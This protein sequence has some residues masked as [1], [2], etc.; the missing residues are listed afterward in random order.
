MDRYWEANLWQPTIVNDGGSVQRF[1]SLRLTEI[2][3]YRE[4]LRQCT[5]A[6]AL[7]PYTPSYWRSRSAVL[8]GLGYPEL[9][10]ADAYKALVLTTYVFDGKYLGSRVWLEMGMV[11]WYGDVIKGNP[12]DANFSMEKFGVQMLTTLKSERKQ[13]YTQLIFSLG[14][15]RALPDIKSITAEALKHYRDDF[16]FLSFQKAATSAYERNRTFIYEQ[17]LSDDVK[18]MKAEMGA[19][20]NKPYPWASGFHT[21][22]KS[23][24]KAANVALKKCSKALRIRPST[25]AVSDSDGVSYG[26]FASQDINEGDIII[27]RS[28]VLSIS[29]LQ[30]KKHLS[31]IDSLIGETK[32]RPKTSPGNCFNCYGLLN[33]SGPEYGFVCCSHLYFCSQN[34][35]NLAKQYYHDALC[36]TN[37]LPTYSLPRNKKCYVWGPEIAG[38]IWLRLLATCKQGGGHP[39]QHPLVANLSNHEAAAQDPWSLEI[40][41]IRPLKILEMLGIDIFANQWYDTW[42]LETLWQIFR[43]N[44]AGDYDAEDE[45]GCWVDGLYAMFNHSCEEPRM[46]G[47][48]IQDFDRAGSKFQYCALREIKKG[49]EV[50]VSY[51]EVLSGSRMERR[52]ALATWLSGDSSKY[53]NK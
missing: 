12:W 49:E 13:A 18:W 35:K 44:S 23:S 47:T 30:V 34:C 51:I 10:A 33:E 8:L 43:I 20:W 14:Y 4:N 2:E 31:L 50:C 40:R 21:R 22:T 11:V 28:P 52:K 48:Y 32:T 16:T 29:G 6:L 19:V 5:K 53:S 24:I 9:A 27:E 7:F 37:I 39:L 42:V 38:I 26:M 46:L 17:S 36:G 3:K 15:L 41:V 1:A 25:V 45:Y